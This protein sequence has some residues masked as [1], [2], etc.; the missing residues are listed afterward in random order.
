VGGFAES[1]QFIDNFV[2]TNNKILSNR[3]ILPDT[4]ALRR[5]MEKQL[6]EQK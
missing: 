1:V 4:V 3:L 5:F 2:K 6:I